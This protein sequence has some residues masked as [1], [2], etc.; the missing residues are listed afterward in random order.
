MGIKSFI[1]FQA[2]LIQKFD[3]LTNKKKGKW[4]DFTDEVGILESLDVEDLCG[5]AFGKKVKWK[6]KATF[7]F[8]FIFTHSLSN[9][10]S[11]SENFRFVKDTQRLPKQ[12]SQLRNSSYRVSHYQVVNLKLIFDI[13]PYLSFLA[14]LKRMTW[15]LLARPQLRSLNK[16]LQL[17]E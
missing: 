9:S 12:D 13:S 16:V 15:S 3:K 10:R 2:T 4:Q 8:A 5:G 17:V 14:I 1:F 6:M 7:K 11:F